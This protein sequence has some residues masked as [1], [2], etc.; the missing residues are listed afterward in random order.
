MDV[1]KRISFSINE[2]FKEVYRV[3]G[4]IAHRR[5]SLISAIALFVLKLHSTLHRVAV[6]ARWVHANQWPYI[7]KHF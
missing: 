7:S 5:R 6:S 3:K 2:T 4:A 1:G